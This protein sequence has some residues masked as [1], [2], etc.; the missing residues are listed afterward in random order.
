MP[1]IGKYGCRA[2]EGELVED[3]KGAEMARIK[4]RATCILRGSAWV[5]LATPEEGI[6]SISLNDK[7]YDIGIRKLES[8]G[9][10][11]DFSDMKFNAPKSIAIDYVQDGKYTKWELPIPAREYKKVAPAKARR[12]NALYKR[13]VTGTVNGAPPETPA[14]AA[15]AAPAAAV[16]DEPRADHA[17]SDIPF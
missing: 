1:E 10:C 13:D 17:Y 4:I 2:I 9:F 15:P 14:P 11:G 6:V 3:S 8:L 5:P 12:L 16:D 7:A